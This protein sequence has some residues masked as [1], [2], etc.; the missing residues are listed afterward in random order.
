MTAD[1]LV[2]S[3]EADPEYQ[4]RLARH[5]AAADELARIC[6]DDEAELLAELASLDI[7][8]E[9][10]YDFVNGGGAPVEAVPVLVAHLTQPHHPRIWEGIVRALSV[11]RAREFALEPLKQAYK[12]EPASDRR[13]ILANAIGT[14]AKLREVQ[15]LDGIAQYKALFGLS[16]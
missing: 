15:D 13:W 12:K 3:L 16:R 4:G 8:A 11:S 5:D 1:E 6:A 9:S 7:N 2:R 10:V 14:M